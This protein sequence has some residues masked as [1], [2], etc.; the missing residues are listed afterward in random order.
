MEDYPATEL[1]NVLKLQRI[2]SLLNG[3]VRPIKKKIIL[4][5]NFKLDLKKLILLSTNGSKRHAAKATC[6]KFPDFL[7]SS[8]LQ[9]LISDANPKERQDLKLIT[10]RKYE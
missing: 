10:P 8:T 2:R 7:S 6:L 9:I 4:M 3:K 1:K 5:N